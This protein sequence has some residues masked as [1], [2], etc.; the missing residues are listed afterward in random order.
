MP[1]ISLAQNAVGKK[2]HGISAFGNLKYPPD[3]TH[4]KDAALEAPKGGTFA[5]IPSNW[6]FNQ[7]VQ[8]FNTLNSF[9]LKGDAPPRMEMCF[10]TLMSGAPDEPDS[11]YCALAS[12][13]EISEDRNTYRFGIR[14]EARFH[15][16]SPVTAED[17]AFT[18]GL[19]KEAGHPSLV[20]SLRDLGKAVVIDEQTIELHFNGNQSDRAILSVSAGVPVFSKAYQES[21][22]IDAST[23]E[24]PLASG[25]WKVGR[26]DPGKYIEYERVK[27]YWAAEMP[28]SK[29][30]GHFDILRIEFAR[31]RAALFQAFKK[32]DITWREEFTSKV[33]ATEYDFPAVRDGRV[34]QK[35][36]P[37]EL[38]PSM[39]GWAINSRKSKFSD[40]R[41][42]EA[43]GLCFDFEWT[44]KNLFY[45]AYTRSASVF[46][47]SDLKAQGKPSPEELAL[48]ES[49]RDQ[50]PKEVFGDA[51]IPYVTDGSG[52]DRKA[53]RKAL[54]LLKAAGW[55]RKDGKLFNAQGDLLSVE[56]LIRD[57]TFKKLLGNYAGNLRKI[58][59]ETSIRLVDPSQYQSR[60]DAFDFD[61][62]GIAARFGPSPTAESL[63]FFLHS[64]SADKNG[65]RNLPGIKSPVI[66]D[67]IGKMKTV[68][69]RDELKTI[70][71]TID[72][73]LRPMHL[74]I[75]NWYAANHRVAYWDMFGW[76]EPKPDYSFAVE[77]LWWYDEEKAKAIGK[78]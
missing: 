43:I 78:A 20:Q 67:L 70:L 26:M 21:R 31:D 28:F 49:Y 13:V 27:D 65:A 8:T 57:D 58:G 50:L 7:N 60:L 25:G 56:F 44:N 29:G 62:V 54:G 12:Y 23:L 76:K 61:M 75:P 32:G 52:N 64:E 10:D 4:F 73:V 48:L 66:D 68:S 18:Y 77:A 59:I 33:W 34:K 9:V 47:K 51:L 17:V 11:L 36:F 22:P 6:A 16:G 2:L 1:E 24:M 69:G 53:L 30:F 14:P 74:W 72:R 39:Q 42:R 38:S 71:K 3:Y 55:E 40:A 41:T 37:S 45:D 5:F 35:L 19:L 46:E 15:D 63:R